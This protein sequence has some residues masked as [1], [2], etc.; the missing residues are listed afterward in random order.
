MAHRRQTGFLLRRHAV[1]GEGDIG[2]MLHRAFGCGDITHTVPAVWTEATLEHGYH[3]AHVLVG[4]PDVGAVV[5]EESQYGGIGGVLAHVFALDNMEWSH[6][7]SDQIGGSLFIQIPAPSA[8]AVA[9]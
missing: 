9:V 1:G 7:N 4:A 5:V 6:G 2:G 3:L 8:A